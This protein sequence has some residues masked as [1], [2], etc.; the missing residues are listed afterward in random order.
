[1]TKK[2][3]SFPKDQLEQL[4]QRLDNFQR[5]YTTRVDEDYD[6]YAKGDILTSNLLKQPLYVSKVQN[7]NGLDQ[8]RFKEHLTPEQKELLTRYKKMQL[9]QIVPYKWGNNPMYFQTAGAGAGRR[10]RIARLLKKVKELNIQPQDI[11]IQNLPVLDQK[12]DK[13]WGNA[14][15]KQGK[16][17]T[18]K[19]FATNHW[20]RIEKANLKYPI[21]IAQD[22]KRVFDGMHRLIKAMRNKRKTIPAYLIPKNVIKEVVQR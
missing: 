8:H 5:I 21:L 16:P 1:M 18:L 2:Y 3:I 7:V 10:V 15:F 14:V 9:L 17:L 19:Q 11:Q 4:K 20:P 22:K 13:I 6:K 12:L